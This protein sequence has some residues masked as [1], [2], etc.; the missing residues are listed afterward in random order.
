[1]TQKF[2]TINILRQM[3]HKDRRRVIFNKI[4]SRLNRKKVRNAENLKWISDHSVEWG[5][6]LS[7]VKSA[8]LIKEVQYATQKIEN[9]SSGVLNSIPFKMG[10]AGCY[11]L[12]YLMVKKIV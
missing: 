9:H 10:G 1:M 3:L 11:P 2:Y 8:S 4:I 7:T 5:E 12:I 6:F